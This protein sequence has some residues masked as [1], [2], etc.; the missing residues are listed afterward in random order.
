M[1]W[2]ATTIEAARERLF[3]VMTVECEAPASRKEF[4]RFYPAVNP[5]PVEVYDASLHFDGACLYAI[6]PY[7]TKP[8]RFYFMRRRG[9]SLS[10]VGNHFGHSKVT[11]HH[12]L[13]KFGTSAEKMLDKRRRYEPYRKTWERDELVEAI[14]AE[15]AQDPLWTTEDDYALNLVPSFPIPPPQAPHGPVVPRWKA[16]LQPAP[17]PLCVGLRALHQSCARL[18][19]AAP[20]ND[21][22]LSR[23]G[24]DRPGDGVG[25]HERRGRTTVRRQGRDVR[26]ED[27]QRC[28]K[29]KIRRPSRWETG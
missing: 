9:M 27:Y 2:H 20:I 16:K 10:Q 3:D 19:L 6:F 5:V 12:S 14:L 18:P 28:Q 24:G 11:V 29:Q 23:V 25:R 8:E 4:P 22:H 1:S 7:P 13:K 26:L 15:P 17:P 21:V